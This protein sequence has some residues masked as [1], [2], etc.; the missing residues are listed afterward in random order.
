MLAAGV[1]G[2]MGDCPTGRGHLCVQQFG[3]AEIDLAT[4][5]S[6]L[7]YEPPAPQSSGYEPLIAGASVAVQVGDAIYIGSYTGDR[8][9]KI[10]LKNLKQ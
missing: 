5:K 9:A 10:T 8:L 3:V 2:V 1:E 4:M 7:I 6:R